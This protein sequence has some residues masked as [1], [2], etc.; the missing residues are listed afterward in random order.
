MLYLSVDTSKAGKCV[1][2]SSQ[3]FV[4]VI[5]CILCTVEVSDAAEINN[6]LN[7]VCEKEINFSNYFIT[8]AKLMGIYLFL[9]SGNMYDRTRRN[10]HFNLFV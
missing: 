10:L 4:T 1:I 9:I 6:C 5:T 2:D 3:G 7:D 8:S